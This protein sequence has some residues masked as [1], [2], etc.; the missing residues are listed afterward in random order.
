MCMLNAF[1][2]RATD[3]LDMKEAKDPVGEANDEHI[4]SVCSDADLVILAYGTHGTYLNRD[5][6]VLSLLAT[7]GVEVHCL[8][9]TKDGLPSHPLYLKGNLQPLPFRRTA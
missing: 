3:P 8:K 4:V 5:R 1:A 7:A 2:F 6:Q 9:H